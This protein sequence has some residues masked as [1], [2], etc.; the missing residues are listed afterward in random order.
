MVVAIGLISGSSIPFH[1]STPVL[2]PVPC[3]CY[4][5]SECILKSGI[6]ILSALIFFGNI[7]KRNNNRRNWDSEIKAGSTIKNQV[8]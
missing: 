3:F 8:I 7:Y 6:V 2:G 1:L 5:G 4:Y